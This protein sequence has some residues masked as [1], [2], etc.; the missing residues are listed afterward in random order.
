LQV[1]GVVGHDEERAGVAADRAAGEYEVS[2][3]RGR[4]TCID[5]IALITAH[6]ELSGGTHSSPSVAESR[7]FSKSAAWATKEK[8]R[9]QF[10]QRSSWSG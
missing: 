7:S 3:K 8:W 5:G 9:P 4:D 2:A 1:F 6:V 10:C